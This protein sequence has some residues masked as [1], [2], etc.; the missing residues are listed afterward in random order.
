MSK[1]GLQDLNNI[2]DRGYGEH[3]DC[4]AK[5]RVM[6][7]QYLLPVNL[8]QRRPKSR[9]GSLKICSCMLCSTHSGRRKVR[10]LE[11]TKYYPHALRCFS[12]DIL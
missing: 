12:E 10:Q 2:I 4:L 11:E 3:A 8:Y 9:Q 1:F 5:T 7:L 6:A